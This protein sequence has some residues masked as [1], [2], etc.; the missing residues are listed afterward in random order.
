[1]KARSHRLCVFSLVG[2]W[3]H[4]LTGQLCTL[5]TFLCVG[6]LPRCLLVVGSGSIFSA[7]KIRGFHL[8]R[9][10]RQHQN[11]TGDDNSSSK[12]S[13]V[14]AVKIKLYMPSED[15]AAFDRLIMSVQLS[16]SFAISSNIL[17][18]VIS[19]RLSL[20]WRGIFYS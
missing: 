7:K 6:R 8:L 1:M 17:L 11:V 18:S 19:G 12:L 15:N 16:H 4:H 13:Y 2:L 20:D 14:T 9:H 10:Q 5:R 3:V